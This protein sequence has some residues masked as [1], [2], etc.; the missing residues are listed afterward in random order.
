[1]NDDDELSPFALAVHA[2]R[3]MRDKGAEDPVI[4]QLPAGAAIFDL[5]V[6]ASGRSERQVTTLAE[7]VRHFCKRHGIANAGV[8]GE[9]GWRVV[10]CYDVVVHAFLED[11]RQRYDLESLWPAAVAIDVDE[12]LAQVPELA[13]EAKRRTGANA[14]LPPPPGWD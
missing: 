9:T 12:A 10:D 2:L 13:G 11:A 8:E 5:V 14:S 4:L 7:E 1:M 6:I 3:A